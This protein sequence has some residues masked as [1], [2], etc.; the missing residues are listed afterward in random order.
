MTTDQH[1]KPQTARLGFDSYQPVR[2]Q[3]PLRLTAFAAPAARPQTREERLHLAM[4]PLADEATWF[5][6]V[7]SKDIELQVTVALNPKVTR[8]VL[9]LI[10]RTA[11]EEAQVAVAAH[12]QMTPSLLAVLAA[13][14]RKSVV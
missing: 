14:D 1:L 3:P 9:E 4:S 11:H 2:K 12:P 6:L 13:S 8:N 5:K 7:Q 10:A